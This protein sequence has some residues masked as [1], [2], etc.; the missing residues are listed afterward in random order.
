[1]KEMLKKGN[2]RDEVIEKYRSF[3]KT[4]QNELDGETNVKINRYCVDFKINKSVPQVLQRRGIVTK[5]IFGFYQW[6]S[7]RPNRKM[8]E[9]ILKE[10]SSLNATQKRNKNKKQKHM[11]QTTEN[12]KRNAF[13]DNLSENV[14][15]DTST[16]SMSTVE[17]LDLVQP[18]S[19]NLRLPKYDIN[20]HVRLLEMTPQLAET[21]LERN[22]NNRPISR[23]S[24]NRILKEIKSGNWFFNAS[25]IIFDEMGNVIDGQYRL[26]S[27]L[28]S[29]ASLP[30][31]VVTG[32]DQ[33]AFTV[34]DSG[35]IRTGG[36]TLARAGIK[37]SILMATTIKHINLFNKGCYGDTSA[38]RTLSSQDILDF[39]NADNLRLAEDVALGKK[40]SNGSNRLVTPSVTCSLLYLFSKKDRTMALDFITKMC[41]GTNISEGSPIN[42]LRNRLMRSKMDT[43]QSL[44]PSTIVKL[45]IH[46]WNKYR[47]GEN[48]KVL[49]IPTEKT[50]T[51]N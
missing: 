10:V 40:L 7:K 18:E 13:L 46:A 3:L 29:G 26:T 38:S 25:T 42:A 41:K 43:T 11:E 15:N 16:T 5:N 48:S 6:N 4:L 31:L 24:L 47:A 34:I 2:N 23:T 14:S 19:F 37:N 51:I 32:V 20:I 27:C 45:I 21:L 35:K 17:I 12:E 44:T 9:G 33:K 50:I 36:D 39:Y 1:M 22:I 8:I 28:E 49:K 30:M